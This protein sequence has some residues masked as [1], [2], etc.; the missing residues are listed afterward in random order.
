ITADGTTAYYG[1]D[2]GTHCVY[3]FVADTPNNFTAG[4]VY[5]LKLDLALSNDEPSSAT[6]TWVLV[7]NTTQADRN[8]L[9]TVASNLGGTNF[10]GVEDCEISPLDGKIYFTSKGKNR[11]YRFKDNGSTISEFETFVEGMNYNIETTSGT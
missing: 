4:K 9:R 2:G 3:K 5:V 11:V 6:A 10:N 8:N 7:P 1:E